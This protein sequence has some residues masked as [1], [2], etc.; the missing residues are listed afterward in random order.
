MSIHEILKKYWGYDA[1]RPKQEE[2][3]QHVLEGYDTLGILPTGGGKSICYQIPALALGGLCIV[4]SPLIALMKDQ[5]LGLAKRGIKCKALY[6]GMS[7]SEIESIYEQLQDG[8]YSFLFVSP[9]RLKTVSFLDQMN[10]WD[11]RLLA[12]DEA[13]CISQWGYDFRPP[14]L[15]IATIRKL[16]PNVPCLAL[17]AS[18]TPLVQ[19]DIIESLQFHNHKIFFTSFA[20][21]NISISVFEVEN[22][23]VKCIDILKKV[24]G[25]AIVYCKNRRRTKELAE[26]LLAHGL[27][28]DFYHAGLQHDIRNARQQD[29]IENRT[30]IIVCTNAFGMGIDKPDVRC[31]IHMDLPD[32]PEAYYQ[33]IGRAGRDGMLSYAV[34]LHNQKDI[35][36]LFDS[37]PL[38]YP[39][40]DVLWSVYESICQFLQIPWYEGEEQCWDFEIAEFI[41]LHSFHAIEVV[42]SMRILELQDYWRLSESIYLPSTVSVICTKTQIEHIEKQFPELDEILKV[43]LRMYGGILNHYV[44]INEFAMSQ[45]LN[46]SKE[47]IYDGLQK[48][49]ALNLIDYVQAKDKPQ[50]TFLKNRV[51]RIDFSLDTLL[52][53]TLKKRYTERIVFLKQWVENTKECRSSSLILFFGETLKKTCG[54][55]DICLR[56]KKNHNILVFE[57]VKNTILQL[58]KTKQAIT[59]QDLSLHY[60]SLS[61]D[62]LKKIIRFLIDDGQIK[63]NELGLLY[64]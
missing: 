10:H 21:E 5:A 22:K 38:K 53:T 12:I 26:Q 30:R 55:C 58:L 11:I 27:Q 42:S 16:I 13:H 50:I 7:K 3:I 59:L 35:A 6:S 48:L 18:A 28:A 9:E 17:T 24:H 4:V 62:E 31:V 60:S 19:K 8:E 49:H 33:E 37:I 44:R 29:W 23:I 54:L 63:I 47:Y 57:E 45:K 40:I 51:K 61:Q 34:L 25:T 1:F 36:Q 2:I 43:L 20:R 32:T 56:K 41:K 39:S 15:E 14:Y 52:L 64:N 46:I